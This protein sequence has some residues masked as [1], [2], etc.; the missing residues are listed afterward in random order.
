MLEN[1]TWGKNLQK[2]ISF[3]I[4]FI[5]LTF[6]AILGLL[7]EYYNTIPSVIKKK[8][9]G[10]SGL[11]FSMER[12]VTS[13]ISTISTKIDQ[14]TTCNSFIN[15]NGRWSEERQRAEKVSRQRVSVF[16]WPVRCFFCELYFPFDVS[17]LLFLLF[18]VESS[19]TQN[20]DLVRL[21]CWR[22]F[23][24]TRVGWFVLRAGVCVLF[25]H[26]GLS[27][28]VTYAYSLVSPLADWSSFPSS[29]IYFFFSNIL[30]CS[31]IPDSQCTAS[32]LRARRGIRQNP[33]N[34]STDDSQGKDR[35]GGE[36]FPVA[37]VAVLLLLFGVGL[38]IF[39]NTSSERW[40]CCVYKI[41]R[42]T[43][44]LSLIY[45]KIILFFFCAW[46]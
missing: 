35:G 9:Q 20:D 5:V 44:I 15:N 29:L 25:S 18:V 10:Q 21:C 3:F 23:D 42:N 16:A 46:V 7:V 2:F 33:T 26:T 19:G 31:D 13:R 22:C 28:Y 32:Q 36:G 4:S 39:F 41:Q 6:L 11:A 34:W 30:I 40:A 37:L 38:I 1:Y 14:S 12:R 24:N 43:R 17:L 45:E 8:Y 27:I